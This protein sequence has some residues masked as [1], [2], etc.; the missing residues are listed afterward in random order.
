MNSISI[1]N[2]KIWV[3]LHSKNIRISKNN[4]ALCGPHC[5]VGPPWLHWAYS[6]DLRI[7]T[8]TELVPL[9]YAKLASKYQWIYGY[10]YSVRRYSV[11]WHI[12]ISRRVAH[13]KLLPFTTPKFHILQ[14]WVGLALRD[15]S[16]ICGRTFNASIITNLLLSVNL[17]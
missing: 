8:Y 10:F 7:E 17:K 14:R 12:R 4:E 1:I 2:D 5:N 6:V 9:K 15:R 13:A 11:S 16:R 3:G